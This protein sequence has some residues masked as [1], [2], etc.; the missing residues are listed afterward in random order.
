MSL[1]NEEA[2]QMLA[3]LGITGPLVQRQPFAQNSP[4]L[5][6]TRSKPS[7][8][9]DATRA[10]KPSSTIQFQQH[11]FNGSSIRS[12]IPQEVL[13][14]LYDRFLRHAPD[15][16]QSDIIRTCF[17][18]EKAHWFYLDNYCADK[19]YS[20]T[21]PNVSQGEFFKIV[22]RQAPLATIVRYQMDLSAVLEEFGHY[23]TNVPTY[24]ACILNHTRDKVLLVLSFSNSY[25]FP[26]G[27][28]NQGE[29]PVACAAREVEEEIGID[30]RDRID[31]NEYLESEQGTPRG[32][33]YTRLYIVEGIAE[34][35]RVVGP[36]MKGEVRKVVWWPIDE[37]M[38]R[39]SSKR[40]PFWAVEPFL[41]P[42][43]Q[44]LIRRTDIKSESYNGCHGENV[45][46]GKLG[47]S[48]PRDTFFDHCL[49]GKNGFRQHYQLEQQ[50]VQPHQNLRS[51]R[52][53]TGYPST[54]RMRVRTAQ[55]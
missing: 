16:E 25:G 24:G 6:D 32:K 29:S 33:L 19:Q 18:I 21:C 10:P 39:V 8:S 13:E 4:T 34:Q 11:S 23:K 22:F 7:T 27:K 37:L 47:Q 31:A 44:W 14:E 53:A 20:N 30:V 17:N 49:T 26:K 48:V 40:G 15:S 42:L 9:L 51:S 1:S 28:I 43:R 41:E 36:K 45:V 12:K 3:E 5:T 55:N 54:S 50:T 38:E 52:P 35:R 2:R 46:N